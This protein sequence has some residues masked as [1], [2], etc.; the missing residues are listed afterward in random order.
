MFGILGISNGL[1]SDHVRYLYMENGT[2]VLRYDATT[3]NSVVIYSQNGIQGGVTFGYGSIFGVS[4]DA[5]TGDVFVGGD[6]TPPGAAT[7]NIGS[8]YVVTAP[9]TTEGIVNTQFGPPC[10]RSFTNAYTGRRQDWRA[11]LARYHQPSRYAVA[12][13]TRVGI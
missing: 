5:P 13:H 3:T 7:T 6:P 9:N 11:I 12:L 10:S 1:A 2:R 4:Y 8:L